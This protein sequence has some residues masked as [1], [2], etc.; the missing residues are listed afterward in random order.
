MLCKIL[1]EKVESR[2][3]ST[4]NLEDTLAGKN[5]T[6]REMKMGSFTRGCNPT[7][8]IN[9]SPRQPRSILALKYQFYV[10]NF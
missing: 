8:K 9:G 7:G 5:K 10:Q 2:E 6:P 3:D 1:E 4:S